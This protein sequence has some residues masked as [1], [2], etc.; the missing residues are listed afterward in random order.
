MPRAC[1][2]TSPALLPAL[3]A[4]GPLARR[5]QVRGAGHVRFRQ[6]LRGQLAASRGR[7]PRP[8]KCVLLPVLPRQPRRRAPRH[9]RRFGLLLL[10]SGRGLAVRLRRLHRAGLR[11][12]A[13]AVRLCPYYRHAMVVV[14]GGECSVSFHDVQQSS[15]TRVWGSAAPGKL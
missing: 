11:G 13:A 8:S 15:G 12:G 6:R 5:P 10:A 9:R 3:A 14:D 7:P 1:T 2:A 4:A